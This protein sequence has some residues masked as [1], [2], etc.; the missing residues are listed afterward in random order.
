MNEI[1]F[2]KKTFK[3]L[4]NSKNGTVDSETIFE[5][6]QN[7]KLITADYH[8]GSI[9]YGKI[10]AKMIDG[11]LEMLYNCLTTSNELKAGKALANIVLTNEGKIKLH[12]D[13]KWFEHNEIGTS[14]YLEI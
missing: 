12:L 11:K 5:Y 4:D 13:W 2:D 1:N 3:L 6:R 7:G 8:G 9:I 10:I 14:I